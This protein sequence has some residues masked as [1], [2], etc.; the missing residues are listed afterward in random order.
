MSTEI[1]GDSAIPLTLPSGAQ[2]ILNPDNGKMYQVTH[3]SAP[4]IA[5]AKQYLNTINQRAQ[6]ANK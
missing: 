6:E 5:E 2:I 1:A 3:L 4:V